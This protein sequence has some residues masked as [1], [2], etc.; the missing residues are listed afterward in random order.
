MARCDCLQHYYKSTTSLHVEMLWICCELVVQLVVQQVHNKSVWWSLGLT[1]LDFLITQQLQ[2]RFHI[3][4]FTH[5]SAN[6][7]TFLDSTV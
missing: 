3:P 6:I 4:H 7:S 5:H 2:S 1:S